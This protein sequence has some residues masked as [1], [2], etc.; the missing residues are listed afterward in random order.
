MAASGQWDPHAS[1]LAAAEAEKNQKYLALCTAAGLDFIP[2]GMSTFGAFGPQGTAFLE[3]L[4]RRSAKRFV[5]EL[6]ERFKG[7]F[8]HHWERVSV[9]LQKAVG[10]S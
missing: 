5:R 6:E 9:A 1:Q 10:S 7:Q 3:R 8:Q 4:F 2:L